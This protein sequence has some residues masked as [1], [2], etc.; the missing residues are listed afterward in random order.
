MPDPSK[1]RRASEPRHPCL[2]P[3]Y[4]MYGKPVRSEQPARL[5]A[6]GAVA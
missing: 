3:E 2:W 5:A 4:F 6:A 1:C